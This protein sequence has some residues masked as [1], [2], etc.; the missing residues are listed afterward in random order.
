MKKIKLAIIVIYIAF[1][2]LISSLT[3]FFLVKIVRQGSD[4]YF[5]QKQAPPLELPF[6]E[7]DIDNLIDLLKKIKL[8]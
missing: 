3:I 5:Q 8:L 2:I 6:K 4:L 1:F 7:S